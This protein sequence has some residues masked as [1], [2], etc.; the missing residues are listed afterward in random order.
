MRRTLAISATVSV[1]ALGASAQ[2]VP[3][4][5]LTAGA[6]FT[7]LLEGWARDEVAQGDKLN[8][9]AELVRLD[10]EQLRALD[11][12]TAAISGPGFDPMSIEAD[13]ATG[14]EEVYPTAVSSGP[15]DPR[16][17]GDGRET[18][19][20]M[21]VQVA[22]EFAGSAGVASAGLS[23][24]QWRCLFQ[25]LVKQESAFSVT[26]ES[27]VGAYGLAQL[28]PGTAADMGVNRYDPMDNLRGGARYITAQLATYGNIPYALAAY[29]AGPGN[30]D[31]YGGIPPFAETQGYVRNITAFYNGYLSTVG[32]PDALGT[33]SVA[34]MALAEYSNAADA[35]THHAAASFMAAMQSTQRLRQIVEAIDSQPD[36]KAAMEL[37]TYA[38]I[39]LARIIT[40]RM[41]LMAAR[42]KFQSAATQ[43]MAADRLSERQFMAMEVSP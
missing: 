16:L 1:V 10:T 5:D 12:I 26:A 38:R 40:M 28:M 27:H 30:V 41:R 7:A 8:T 2:G 36:A 33:L 3:D 25:A 43:Q 37:N 9:R 13:T 32:G 17:F 18:V 29:N 42:S 20:M 11:K 31:K 19:E 35:S 24:T 34:D 39:E 23:P 6:R 22:G 21:I 4:V 14:A 15:M